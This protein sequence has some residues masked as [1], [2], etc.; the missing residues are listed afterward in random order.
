MTKDSL[1]AAEL[2]RIALILKKAPLQIAIKWGTEVFTY[3]GKNVVSYGGFKNYCAIWFYNGVFLSDPYSVLINAQ[4]GKTKALR[5]W[6]FYNTEEIEEDKILE[7]VLEAI[8]I[9]KQGLK[10]KSDTPVSLP[11]SMFLEIALLKDPAFKT[12]FEQLTPGRQREYSTYIEEAKQDKTKISRV[13]KI[14]PMI[15][16]G[17]GLNDKYK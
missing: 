3:N 4:E 2:N 12:A 7:Y 6:R 14:I 15:L 11:I 17:T 9:E 1:W 16:A 5:Q 8:E 10:I 13:A